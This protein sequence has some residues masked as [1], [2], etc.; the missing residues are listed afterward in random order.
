MNDLITGTAGQ[1]QEDRLMRGHGQPR[2]ET[3][4]KLQSAAAQL[5]SQRRHQMERE[6]AVLTAVQERSQR[7]SIRRFAQEAGL[8]AANLGKVL[9]GHRRLSEDML[10]RLEAL[11]ARGNTDESRQN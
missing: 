6:Q 4:A 1:R 11:L 10:T 8:N 5:E 2:P 3:L 7:V 9:R